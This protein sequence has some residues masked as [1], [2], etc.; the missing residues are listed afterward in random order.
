MISV[1]IFTHNLKQIK[2]MK[3]FL[4]LSLLL[5]LVLVSC[6]KE[7]DLSTYQVNIFS[8][9][10]GIIEGIPNINKALEGEIIT[11]TAN[12]SSENYQNYIFEGWSGTISSTENPLKVVVTGN[13]SITAKFRLRKFREDEIYSTI[14]PGD[15]MSF[16]KAFIADAARYGYDLSY[17]DLE[18]SEFI[19][20]DGD[21]LA[22]SQGSCDPTAAYIT[23]HTDLWNNPEL[24]SDHPFHFR[25]LVAIVWHE[26]GH[27]LLQLH[28]LCAGGHFMSGRHQAPQGPCGDEPVHKNVYDIEYNSNDL[29]INWQ[30]AAEDMFTL[31]KQ[32]RNDCYNKQ[33]NITGKSIIIID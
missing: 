21:F 30:R 11:L 33:N 20:K 5:S 8:T 29:Y 18:K 31:N 4:K 22:Y 9:E 17:V 13:M 1:R 12:P 32:Y 10:G 27:D 15:M 24:N 28:H 7:Q 3:H 2:V 26:L 25:V 16:L 6:S 14:I 19:I 23:L